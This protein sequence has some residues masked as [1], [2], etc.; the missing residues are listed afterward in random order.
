[1]LSLLLSLVF[2]LTISPNGP[3][4]VEVGKT[5]HLTTGEQRVK[6]SSANSNIASVNNQGIVYGVTPGETVVR[7]RYKSDSAQITV[8]VRQTQTEVSGYGPSASITCPAGATDINPGESIQAAVDA[9]GT[10][11]TFCLRAGTFSITSPITPKTGDTFVG[12]FGAILDGTSWTSTPNNYDAAFMAHNQDIDNVTIR[13][14]VIQNMPERG[15]HAYPSF[16]DGWVVEYTEVANNFSGVSVGNTS[17]VRHCH[18]HHNT[19][20]SQG[21]NI[22]NGGYIVSLSHDVL[23]ED[24]EI[25]H[26]GDTQKVIDQSTNIT[27]RRNYVHDNA[28]PG[29]WLDGDDSVVLVEDNTIEDN[30]TFGVFYEISAYGTIRNN[31]IR[32]SGDSG[33]FISTSHDVE[34]YGNTLEDNFRSVNLIANCSIIGGGSL[35]WDLANNNIHNNIINV[36]SQVGVLAN[37]LS[38][39]G[40]CSATYTNGSKN[41]VFESNT[42]AVPDV[43]ASIWYW[44]SSKTFTEWQALGND[45]LGSV[46]VR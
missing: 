33:I 38:T 28:G 3:L 21:G 45:A 26:N 25:D 9:A 24:N 20:D 10:G 37:A 30:G 39:T 8:R 23:F 17:T 44:E 7:A 13:N 46:T 35:T 22:P 12:E 1:M 43:N 19:G 14:L 16:S 34:A 31:I 32:R 42:Y 5:V 41:N 29:I 4:E 27:F 15:I 11:T 18:L 2:A 36:G 40:P 6:W